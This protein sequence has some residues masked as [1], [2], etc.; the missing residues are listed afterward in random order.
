M[1]VLLWVIGVLVV[2]IMWCC[3]KIGSDGNWY[4]EH[5]AENAPD[6]DPEK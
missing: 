2:F 3:S 6:N 1:I 5:M 4:T